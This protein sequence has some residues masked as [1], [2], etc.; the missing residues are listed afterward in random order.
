MPVVGQELVR[1]EHR[2][3]QAAQPVLVDDREH[4]PAGVGG[5]GGVLD[6][7]LRLGPVLHEPVGARLEVGQPRDRLGADR[8]HRDE[9]EQAHD[10]P[11]R[12][13]DRRRRPSSR[14]RS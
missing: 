8:G 13:R 4:P 11:G 5:R 10:R 7:V 6:D 14:S 3:E 1:V 9:R 12:Q 2:A